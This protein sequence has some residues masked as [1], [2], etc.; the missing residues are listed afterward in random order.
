[1]KRIV[2]EITSTIT[3]TDILSLAD[4]KSWLRVDTTD[5]DALITALI[6]VAIDQ[7]QQY[8]G[9]YLDEVTCVYHMSAFFDTY[10]PVGPLRSV[11][12]VTYT[13]IDTDIPFT[14]YYPETKGNSAYIHFDSPPAIDT[15]N[16]LPVK[17]TAAIGYPQISGSPAPPAKLLHAVRLML[18]QY[19]D[20]RENFVVGTIVSREIPN[21]VK[22][23]MS[24]YRNTYFV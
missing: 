8:T 17:I 3:G 4:A 11:T 18:S 7:V 22:A 10:L 9:Q 20:V 21:G 23:L 24:E 1:M 15:E 12:S 14:A 19:Y 6:D 16:V 13:P 2:P 5:E